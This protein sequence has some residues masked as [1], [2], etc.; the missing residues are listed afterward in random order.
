MK[1]KIVGGLIA[2][3][4]VSTAFLVKKKFF[5]KKEREFV[6]PEQETKTAKEEGGA[7]VE[8]YVDALEFWSGLYAQAAGLDVHVEMADTYVIQELS[9]ELIERELIDGGKYIN[10]LAVFLGAVGELEPNQ[11]MLFQAGL[12]RAFNRY[13]ECNPDKM[14][15]NKQDLLVEVIGI[16][17]PLYNLA[18]HY[19]GIDSKEYQ[20]LQGIE[21]TI[22]NYAHLMKDK[23]TEQQEEDAQKEFVQ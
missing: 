7:Y 1:N 21:D 14:D 13:M 4:I 5:P 3:A 17:G 18:E 10:N 12:G 19:W 6:P 9:N 20:A 15:P 16:M 8:D 11:A 2:T 22:G 23:V